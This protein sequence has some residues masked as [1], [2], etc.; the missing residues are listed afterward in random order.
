MQKCDT[1]LINNTVD[2]PAGLL[3]GLR[4]RLQL[5]ND[6]ALARLLQVS[7]PI[8]SKVRL[9]KLP[10]S[11]ALLLRIHDVTHIPLAE[12]R[13]GMTPPAANAM[14][15]APAD[16]APGAADSRQPP[17]DPEHL[18]NQLSALL[19]AKNDAA[20]SRMLDV[21]PSII[22]RMRRH[23]FPVSGSL[24]I[25][26]HQASNLSI[27]DLQALMRGSHPGDTQ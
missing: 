23:Q 11:P 26:M 18:L 3:D 16:A 12:L 19:C 10:V 2:H 9:R 6:A 8:L 13:A 1:G 7:P 5:K 14:P 21:S 25:K 4:D 20:L 24:L 22:S 15:A 17:Y 27:R